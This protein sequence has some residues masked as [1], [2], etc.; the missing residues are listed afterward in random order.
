MMT[1]TFS[2]CVRGY[3]VYKD[4]WNPSVG[5]TVNCEREGRNPEYPYAVAL[6]KD[7]IIVGH[8]PRTIS[9]VCTLFLRRGGAIQCTV[10]GPRK[11]SDDLLHG[12]LELPCTYRFT[13]P[14]NV[15]KKAH[16]LLLDDQ[17]GVSDLQGMLISILN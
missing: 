16:Q 6:R 7:G 2:S 9:C 11:Y 5:E 8:V 14:D 13:G 3:H 10:T 12:G 17:D 1:F 15:T 4:V